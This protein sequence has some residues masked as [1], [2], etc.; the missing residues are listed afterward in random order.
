M[1]KFWRERF[2]G[3]S[4]RI[5]LALLLVVGASVL[6]WA[7]QDYVVIAPDWDGQ[8]RGIAYEPSHQFV[9]I[10][11]HATSPE[12]I[13]RDLKQIAQITGRV[14][15]YTVSDGLDRV[16]EIARRYGL[17]VSLG[18]WIGPDLELNEKEIETGIRVALANRRTVDRVFVGNEALL[19]GYV[20]SDQLNEYIRRVRAA[21]PNRIK[22]STAEPWSQ[23]LL[24]P[25]IGQYVDF[26]TIH[27]LPYWEGVPVHGSL[28]SLQRF[29]ADV[30]EEFPDK[31]IVIGEA[32]WPSAGRTHKGAEASP[33]NQAW[34]MR[35]FVL[36]ALD[37]GYDYYLEEAYDQPWKGRH[38]GAVG[39][40]WGLFD[41]NGNPKFAFTGLLRSFPAWR[42]YALC[43]A[44]LSLLFGLLILGRMPRVRQP[45]YL[46][47]GA[48]VGVISTGLLVI[49]DTTS[50]EYIEPSD[51]AMT[52]A[53][54]PLIFF[55][56]AVI[57][58]EGVELASSLWRVERRTLRAAIPEFAPRVSVHVPCYNEPPEMV[59]A[60]LDALARLDYENY[61]V[62]VLDNN[63]TDPA[64][65]R[66]VELHCGALGP[67]FRFYHL[68]G[69]RG[70]KAGALNEALRLTDPEAAFVAV[71]DSDYQVEPCWLRRALPYFASA[72]VALV[73]GPQ[74][75]RDGLA[76]TFKRMCFEEYR[77]FFHIGMV[78]R[79]EYDA[80][81]QHGTMTIVRRG[82]LEQVGGWS[83]WCITEDTELGLKLFEAGYGAAY[84]PQ[85]M[86]KGL[87][88]DTLGAF[89]SQRHRWV[90]G[91][92]QILKRH[93][94]A[95]FL[96]RTRL[97]WAQRYQFLCGWL[98]W[99]SD[100]LGLLVTLFALGWTALMAIAPNYFDVPMEALSAAALALFGAK[101]LKTLLLYPQK[102]GSGVLGAV[103]ASTAGL[104]LTH[105]VGKA[106]LSGLFTSGKPF[107]RTP[108]CQNPAELREA[109]HLVWQEMSL[110]ALLMLAVIAM[111]LARGFDDPAATLW[112]I[113]LA[114]Q[115]LPYLATILT[116][117]ISA[118]SYRRASAAAPVLVAAAPPVVEP[119]LPKA[120]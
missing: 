23:W 100:G 97:S 27:L 71:I 43:A 41:A 22:V 8:V 26:I 24:N 81:I 104:A 61:E 50:L 117:C 49:L 54:I 91:A 56:A 13:D 34:F 108:K 42:S 37:K 72:N 57:I 103:L 7:S 105:T 110:F 32:G 88:P 119:V 38:E 47:M 74:D 67:A 102:V 25:E 3:G 98:P 118:T 59:I 87:T 89:M 17:T 82:V 12:Q 15:T 83:M 55:A 101:S 106:V 1:T 31:P 80:I 5:A 19:F 52:L 120:A 40:Y 62:I 94:G 58:T 16:P 78:E 93:A 53:M 107:L 85:S 114:I 111:L 84:I 35:N 86:G 113:M 30:Q 92:M 20:D 65:W 9:R 66:P 63:T 95:M 45:G 90:Y 10:E 75:Y 2:S 77:G 11:H 112:M 96:G 14:R 46:V 28:A 60:T 109:L 68:D 79:N 36:L 115:S 4:I 69:V 116:A 44:L 73:Q 64:T 48:L 33:A 21:L 99:I 70:F 39:A 6:F 18:L 29:Y 51:L 76:T